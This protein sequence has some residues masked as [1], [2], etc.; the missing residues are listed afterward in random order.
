MNFGF[1]IMEISLPLSTS[2]CRNSTQSKN[3]NTKF[4]FLK[5]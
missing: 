5:L 2:L 3:Y 1:T 4:R